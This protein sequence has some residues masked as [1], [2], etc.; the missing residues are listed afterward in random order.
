MLYSIFYCSTI[1]YRSL[2]NRP[3]PLYILVYTKFRTAIVRDST[4]GAPA[5]PPQSAVEEARPIIGAN[6]RAGAGMR[7]Q[8][9]RWRPWASITGAK[10]L[11]WKTLGVGPR[12]GVMA[13]AGEAG[14][15]F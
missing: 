2:G 12:P 13:D 9:C 4:T 8:A 6:R 15:S 3:E 7:A 1:R 11:H 5:H 14:V 10:K